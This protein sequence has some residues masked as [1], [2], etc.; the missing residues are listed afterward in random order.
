MILKWHDK[1]DICMITTNDAGGDHVMQVR[2]K[3]H[4]VDLSVPTVYVSYVSS[5]FTIDFYRFKMS[6]EERLV[7]LLNEAASCGMIGADIRDVATEYFT[8]D[9]RF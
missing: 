3:Q 9:S 1:R 7:H 8:H 4:H 2:R 6:K 5:S